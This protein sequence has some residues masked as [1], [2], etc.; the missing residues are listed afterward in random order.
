MSFNYGENY[1]SR[2]V[3]TGNNLYGQVGYYFG[4]TKLMPYAAFQWGDYEGLEAPLSTLDLG[5]NYFMKGHNTKI[6]LEYHRM[7]GDIREAA[8]T[9]S[10][11]VM[12]Q[13][14]MQ[15]QIFL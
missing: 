13:L 3:G 14:R 15:L 5:V 10:K 6:T 11:D 4:S 12:S 8:I 1:V 7:R 2:W 9:D